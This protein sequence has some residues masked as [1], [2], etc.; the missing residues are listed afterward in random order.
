MKPGIDFG[1]VVPF[2]NEARRLEAALDGL[3]VQDLRNFAVVLVD[4]GSTDGSAALV[5]RSEEIRT[6]RWLLVREPRIGKFHALRTGT[7]VAID[8]LGA[9]WIGFVDA[10]A[11]IEDPAWSDRAATAL[12][13]DGGEPGYV[14]GPYD[15]HEVDHL[16]VFG[17]AY[18]AYSAVIR[19]VIE[20]VGWFGH[21]SN[22]VI[23]ADLLTRYFRESEVTTELDLRQS[24]FALYA[25]RRAVLN[26]VGVTVSPR[27]LLV[28]PSSFAAWCFYDPAFYARKDINARRKLDLD[29][30][31]PVA[32]LR[33]DQVQLFFTRRAAKL[34]ARD[35]IPLALWDRSGLFRSRIEDRLG[36]VLSDRF[37]AD[38]AWCRH[39]VRFILTSRREGV[40]RAIEQ[41]P[42]A[43]ALSAH[44][45]GLM[46]ARHREALPA[47]PVPS[48]RPA[49]AGA[50][51]A[52]AE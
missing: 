48:R 49:R 50:L 41:H 17:A 11:R 32:D 15:Y 28:N 9:R 34:V 35:L 38:F 20:Q 16:P 8:R 19:L 45:A 42:D 6:G 23:A 21:G 46:L 24:L 25:G 29:R 30:P 37:F 13:R 39:D 7:E 52:A 4:N 1:V 2:F 47:M 22:I 43:R 33:E 31:V 14:F 12:G 27:R 18:A 26:P 10:D 3:R 36:P 51:A 44:L 40:V 5:E